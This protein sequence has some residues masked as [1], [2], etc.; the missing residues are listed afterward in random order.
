LIR[1]NGMARSGPLVGPIRFSA[2]LLPVGFCSAPGAAQIEPQ[3][4]SQFLMAMQTAFTILAALC[5]RGIL[6]AGQRQNEAAGE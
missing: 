1:F 3:T 5:V 2:R 4:Y 6:L